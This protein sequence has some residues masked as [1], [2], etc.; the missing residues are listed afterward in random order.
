MKKNTPLVG[1]RD[2]FTLSGLPQGTPL[3]VALSGG[4]DSVVLLSLLKSCSPLVAVHVHHGIRGEEAD[5]DA[6]FCET[7][8]DT[9][10]VPFVLLRVDA[11]ARARETGESLETAARECRYKALT[12]F[13]ASHKIPLLATA[14][15][16]DD[17]LETM[18]Q[19]LL[20]GSGTR[21]LCGIPA[22]RAMGEGLFVVRPLLSVPKADLLSFAKENRLDFVTD[23]T[24]E[25]PCCQRNVLRL[26]VIPRLL[27]LQ[28]NAARLAA[29]CAEAL[30]GDE[31][32]LDGL[33]ADFLKKE[34]S[35]PR[36][37]ELLALPRPI[38]VRVLRRLLPEPPSAQH[39]D[40]ICH[41]L[42]TQKTNA[43]LSLPPKTILRK[44]GGTVKVE[45][46]RENDSAAGPLLLCRD[47]TQIK[48]A[49]GLVFLGPIGKT[50]N[51]TLLENYT[52]AVHFKIK[53]DAVV[54][55][56]SLRY[57]K[58]GDVILSGKMHKTVRR[59]S[60]LSHL[61]PDV[62]ARIPLLVDEAGILA[63]PFGPVRDGAQKSPDLEVH[64]YFH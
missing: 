18:L 40:A 22:C 31:A 19:H 28:P 52:Y 42:K 51:D 49:A 56:L 44:S 3:A 38:L 53:K 60:A 14:H 27:T 17:Q 16:A 61:S 62:R 6:A 8:A 39:V 2:P 25:E 45:K 4:A 50:T 58:P 13:L 24:N 54:G 34:G 37:E 12:D 11:P 32:Y 46:K 43:S 30:S 1:F 36:V 47:Q 55:E 57:R 23:S 35:E 21:G 59:L 15:H 26:Q 48:D 5:R 63:V 29:R 10:N 7:L 20:R 33:A 64:V 41:L 9:M